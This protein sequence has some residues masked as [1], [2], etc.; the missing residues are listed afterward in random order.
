[1]TNIKGEVITIWIIAIRFFLSS[2]LMGR[3]NKHLHDVWPAVGGAAVGLPSDLSRKTSIFKKS[4][5]VLLYLLAC[6]NK[7]LISLLLWRKKKKEEKFHHN[8][9][10]VSRVSHAIGSLGQR[11][12]S[13]WPSVPSCQQAAP[14]QRGGQGD[15]VD[16]S[17]GRGQSHSA[18]H[19]ECGCREKMDPSRPPQPLHMEPRS[20]HGRFPTLPSSKVRPGFQ[21]LDEPL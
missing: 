10:L 15:P 17:S 8:C 14:H 21:V 3:A 1:M 4:C 7:L 2:H 6:K 9:I 13:E 19:K 12:P 16:R 18:E 20:L 11:E 5:V